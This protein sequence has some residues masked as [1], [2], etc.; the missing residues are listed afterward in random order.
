MS[1]VD[2]TGLMENTLEWEI[3]REDDGSA[4]LWLGGL[5][6]LGEISFHINSN[7]LPIQPISI[8]LNK[9][10]F[11]HHQFDILVPA[12]VAALVISR[13]LGKV[14]S[15]FFHSFKLQEWLSKFRCLR[16]CR[17]CHSVKC[18]PLHV[19]GWAT[20]RQPSAVKP[21][22]WEGLKA[23]EMANEVMQTKE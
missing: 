7:V 12:A 1:P 20:P 11:A 3:I 23:I 15:P 4:L 16:H 2:V 21:W 13:I 10:S 14:P 6:G 8:A 18:I 22:V 9:L 17:A 5:A 19:L